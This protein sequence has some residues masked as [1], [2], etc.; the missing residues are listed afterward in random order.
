MN[1][2]LAVV[3]MLLWNERQMRQELQAAAQQQRMVDVEDA[4]TGAGLSTPPRDHTSRQ[5]R[6]ASTAR[7]RVGDVVDVL[8]DPA[9][10]EHDAYLL[11]DQVLR[12]LIP[13]YV[14]PESTDTPSRST[15]RSSGGSGSSSGSKDG[16]SAA[17]NGT[18]SS[19]GRRRQRT[20]LH[21]S[22]S[23]SESGE[24][25]GEDDGDGAVARQHQSGSRLIEQVVLGGTPSSQRRRRRSGASR[26]VGTDGGSGRG[27][28]RPTL[29]LLGVPGTPTTANPNEAAPA[30]TN[31]GDS[32][33]FAPTQ[34]EGAPP[35]SPS[36][37]RSTPVRR[38]RRAARSMRMSMSPVALAKRRL[39]RQLGPRRRSWHTLAK[40]MPV[41]DDEEEDAGDNE[42]DLG[43]ATALEGAAVKHQQQ[44][45]GSDAVATTAASKDV[46]GGGGGPASYSVEELAQE[47]TAVEDLEGSDN[48]ED[49]SGD[50]ASHSTALE[51]V[52]EAASEVE[53]SDEG[54]GGGDSGS[55]SDGDNDQDAS[56]AS[57][58]P[59][60]DVSE[61]GEQ[62]AMASDH[63]DDDGGDGDDREGDDA[64]AGD[65]GGD[66]SD[67][68]RAAYRAHMAERRRQEQQMGVNSVMFDWTRHLNPHRM[69]LMDRMDAIQVQQPFACHTRTPLSPCHLVTFPCT[70][71]QGTL[72]SAA[73]PELAKALRDQG[74]SPAMYLLR[75]LRLAL[76]REFSVGSVWTLWDAVFAQ[77]P[78]TFDLLD[79]V[80]LA[81]VLSI[82]DTLLAAKDP[83]A[84]LQALNGGIETFGTP[85]CCVANTPRSKR[86]LLALLA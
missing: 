25:D 73:D 14:P 48:D 55:G 80:C 69:P 71:E 44:R 10:V 34:E 56:G 77:S 19:S 75:W 67:D 1:E 82:R 66:N 43:T 62:G 18:G 72:L 13:L 68:E 28:G 15:K 76:A 3:V 31:S 38:A 53:T 27:D 21:Q 7:S 47:A 8:I 32:P 85:N 30:S 2:L 39:H 4:T 60:G 35:R 54:S 23:E 16:D 41:D 9:F 79:F 61:A 78:D 20:T 37:S 49:D 81:M 84:L 63:D 57:D 6:P 58:G 46:G 40:F 52:A 11:L 70:P 51:D 24:D 36:A 83:P 45:D 86:V 26:V 29:P 17:G 59:G 42:G 22:S 64:G 33:G 12:R 50:V 74:I 65:D 5:R